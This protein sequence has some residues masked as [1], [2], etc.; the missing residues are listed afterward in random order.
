MKAGKYQIAVSGAAKGPSVKQGQQLASQLGQALAKSGQT[1][2]T[3]A[4]IGLSY[5][6]AQAAQG[7]GGQTIGISP[8]A[9]LHAHV[10]KY[11]LPT[12]A[13]DFIIFTGLDYV[14]RDLMLTQT[15]DATIVVGGRIG[16]LHEFTSALEAHKPVGVLCGAGGT[17]EE[18]DD[19]LK[20][21]GKSQRHILFDENP[22]K[23]VKRLLELL[24]QLHKSHQEHHTEFGYKKVGKRKK[25]T[26]VGKR[27]M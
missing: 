26:A 18:I 3:G 21:A 2:F 8:A 15:T 16:T 14:G 12:D 13:Y 10:N 5:Y 20:A 23:L 25:T 1:V 27:K 24:D 11:R 9:S 19:I 4:T 6:S 17:S 22:K 7:A